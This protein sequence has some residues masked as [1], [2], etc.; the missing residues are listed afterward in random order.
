MSDALVHITPYDGFAF[1]NAL[2]N[3]L[4]IRT[5]ATQQRVIVSPAKSDM[6]DVATLTV[7]QTEVEIA[8]HVLAAGSVVS[9]DIGTAGLRLRRPD[10]SDAGAASHAWNEPVRLRIGHATST[11]LNYKLYDVVII[12]TQ[13]A[14]RSLSLLCGPSINGRRFV[15]KNACD[16]ADDVEVS[17]AL[18]DGVTTLRTVNVAAGAEASFFGYLDEWY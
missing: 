6:T 13:D 16:D 1:G 11:L 2:T 4:C 18:V 5:G 10:A 7:G 15:V 8:G 3:D 9:A 14:F 12:R 17:I